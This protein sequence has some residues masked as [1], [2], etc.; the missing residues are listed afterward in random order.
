MNRWFLILLVA[1]FLTATVLACGK[2]E[3][4]PQVKKQLTEKQVQQQTRQAL[5]TLKAYTEQQKEAYQKKVADQVAEMQK[6]LQELK[7]QFDKAAPEMKA[8]LEKELGASKKD[9]DA[10]EK[11]LADMKTAT[12]KAWEDMRNS[13]NQTVEN[14]QKSQK[15]EKE[16]K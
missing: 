9:L 8:R 14:W 10:L 3:E 15:S 13:V 11:N 1:L 12:G 4:A 2:K 6:K 5:D 16:G 7:G